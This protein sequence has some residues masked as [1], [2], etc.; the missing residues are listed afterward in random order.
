MTKIQL[1]IFDPQ[2]LGI[3][4]KAFP[5]GRIFTSD[6]FP[7]GYFPNVQFPKQKLPKGQVMPSEAPQ[8]CNGGRA[9]RLLWVREAECCCQNR[10]WAERCVQD[11]LGKLPPGKFHIWEV[12][13][14]EKTLGK[15]PLGKV[16]NIPQ[17][18]NIQMIPTS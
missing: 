17:M 13:T 4:P 15:L 7:S 12:S 1:M 11:R 6:N 2:V 16:P 18:S 3:F 5:Q 8:G 9:M 14:W 10:L